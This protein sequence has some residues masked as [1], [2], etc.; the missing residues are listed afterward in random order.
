MASVRFRCEFLD[1]TGS[2]LVRDLNDCSEQV[3]QTYVCKNC[4]RVID[5]RTYDRR[6][7]RRECRAV[8]N[9]HLLVKV[10]P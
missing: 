9:H 6:E 2:P 7:K 10:K 1:E 4:H 3:Y 5:T 8:M